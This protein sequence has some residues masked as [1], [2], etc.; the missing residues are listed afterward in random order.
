MFVGDSINSYLS[1]ICVLLSNKYNISKNE[2]SR[3]IVISKFYLLV[4]S[5][6]LG[7]KENSPEF[8]ADV[9]YSKVQNGE[10]F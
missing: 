8:W 3:Y 9:I 10:T 4:R 5:N 2:A 6:F 7:T 1:E